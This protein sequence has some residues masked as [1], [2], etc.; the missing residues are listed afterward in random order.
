LSYL[1]DTQTDKQ[2]LA[3]RNLLGGGKYAESLAL[4]DVILFNPNNR[5]EVN[6]PSMLAQMISEWSERRVLEYE[7]PVGLTQTDHTND[8]RTVKR[9]H[10]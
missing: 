10:D 4:Q 6:R 3:K 2:S 8:V 1:A 5:N 9:C 7:H